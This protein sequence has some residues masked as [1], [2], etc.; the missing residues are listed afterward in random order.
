MKTNISYNEKVYNKFQIF[1]K[2]VLIK[3]YLNDGIKQIDGIY[4]PSSQKYKNF[5]F[6][7]GKVVDLGPEVPSELGIKID[8]IVLYDYYSANG[9]WKDHIITNVENLLLKISEDEIKK[10]I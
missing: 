3:K 7:V 8:D 6:G 5:K 4:V 10:F 1:G 2:N 9:D